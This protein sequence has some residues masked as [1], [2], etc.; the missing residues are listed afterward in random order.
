M[1]EVFHRQPY[2]RRWLYR[3]HLE[4]QIGRNDQ[5][6]IDDWLR[7]IVVESKGV[8]IDLQSEEYETP[9][10]SG[11]IIP[12]DKVAPKLGAMSFYFEHPLKLLQENLKK[13]LFL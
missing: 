8:L 9:T 6:W 3:V 13:R 7:A 10:K 1:N 4:G 5:L 11:T 2:R 12:N